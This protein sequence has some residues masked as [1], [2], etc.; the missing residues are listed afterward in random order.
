MFAV[1]PCLGLVAGVVVIGD[2]F[3]TVWNIYRVGILVLAGRK[4][5]G[6]GLL[7]QRRA[8]SGKI[9]RLAAFYPNLLTGQCFLA[10]IAAGPV[11]GI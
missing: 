6:Q 1:D 10:L 4:R 2:D 7:G 5:I 9:S 3:G 8:A 11:D